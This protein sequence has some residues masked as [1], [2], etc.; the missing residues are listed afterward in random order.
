MQAGVEVGP[1][2]RKEFVTDA[3]AIEVDLVAAEPG[4]VEPRR[5]GNLG[6]VKRALHFYGAAGAVVRRSRRGGAILQ[7][8]SGRLLIAVDAPP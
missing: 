3:L 5:F 2:R 8:G 6:E 1:P 7:D 4:D